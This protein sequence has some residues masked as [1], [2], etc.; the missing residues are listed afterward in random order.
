MKM[1]KS[2]LYVLPIELEIK[3]T[4]KCDV[5][6]SRRL[7]ELIGLIDYLLMIINTHENSV[8]CRN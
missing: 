3:V 2:K 8:M 1:V 5:E 6:V 4:V 7:N